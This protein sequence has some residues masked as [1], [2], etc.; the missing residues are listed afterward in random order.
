MNSLFGTPW[1]GGRN[2]THF[3]TPPQ[4]NSSDSDSITAGTDISHRQFLNIE[5]GVRLF[6]VTVMTVEGS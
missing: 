5:A 4:K 1:D 6:V 3:H 2:F